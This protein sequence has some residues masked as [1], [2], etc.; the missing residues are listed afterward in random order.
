MF[1]G[2]WKILFI[3][4]S[5]YDYCTEENTTMVRATDADKYK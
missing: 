4:E 5:I 1:I 2:W 3:V